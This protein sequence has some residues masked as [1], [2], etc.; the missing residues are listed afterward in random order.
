[1]EEVHKALEGMGSYKVS[2]LDGFQVVFF[3]RTWNITGHTVYSFVQR[4]LEEE[5]YPSEEAETLLILIPKETKP[6][7]IRILR[8]INLSNAI[9]KLISKTI[10]NRLRGIL[11]EIIAPTQTGFAPGRQSIDNVIICQEI[12]HTLKY[13][14]AKRGR[15]V[16]KLDLEKAHDRME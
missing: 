8:P 7:S 5:E 2:G 6:S 3:K 12:I 11:G 4:V 9:F 16:I 10:V 1:M 15:M 14:M 13:T